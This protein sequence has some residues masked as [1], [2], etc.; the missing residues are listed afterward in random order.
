MQVADPID[1]LV[2]MTCVVVMLA[3]SLSEL[4]NRNQHTHVSGGCYVNCD[5]SVDA[6]ATV[7]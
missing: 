2:R 7:Y 6:L 3:N 4:I 1:E 5:M